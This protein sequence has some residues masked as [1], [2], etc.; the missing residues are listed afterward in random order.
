MTLDQ[1]HY[2]V[3]TAQLESFSQAAA[4]LHISQPSLSISIHKLEAELEIELFYPGRRKAIMTDAGRVFLQD[5]QAILSQVDLAARHMEQFS[6]KH[7]AQLR[8]A[9]TSSMAAGYIPRLLKAFLTGP[10][11]DSQIY[12]DEIPSD[13]V[14]AGIRDGRFDLG[15]GSRIPEDTLVEQVPLFSQD[16]CLI[17]PASYE[18]EPYAASLTPQILLS[19][20][21]ICYHKDYPMY[22]SLDQLFHTW[23]IQPHITHFSYSE[24]SIALLVEQEMGIALVAET[25]NLRNHKIQILHPA[26]LTGSRE[27]YLLRPTRRY[28]SLASKDLEAF[29]LQFH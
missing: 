8:L 24:D 17:I 21:L 6:Q 19:D 23:G 13:Q 27:I 9:Y 3:A 28:R 15:I 25:E 2:Y 12:T 22:R 5:A 18:K 7:Q 10:Y 26:W 29:I 4:T 20:N 14:A 1:L 11:A 16:F